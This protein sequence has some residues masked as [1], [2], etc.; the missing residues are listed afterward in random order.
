MSAATGLELIQDLDFTPDVACESKICDERD[1]AADWYVLSHC[2][3]IVAFCQG[4]IDR[5][6]RQSGKYLACAN[7]FEVWLVVPHRVLGPVRP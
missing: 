5:R 7:C 4:A 2:R 1:H 3:G 6:H